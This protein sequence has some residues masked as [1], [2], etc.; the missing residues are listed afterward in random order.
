M[1]Y[2]PNVRGALDLHQKIYLPL[3]AEIP[4]LQLL[5]IGRSPSPEVQAIA[6]ASVEVTGT[7]ESIWPHLSKVD[8]F[9]FPMTTGAGLQNK[10]LEAMHAG[11]P[12]VTTEICL[13]SV[14]AREGDEILVGR[15]DD[16]L[17]AHVRAL[18]INP[19][20]ARELGMRGKQYVDHTFEMSRVIDRFENFLFPDEC[21]PSC[22]DSRQ[23]NTHP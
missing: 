19:K 7:V 13:K 6:E 21:A 14:G 20:F 2:A 15:N 18:L 16:E 5:V 22:R 9:V 23:L 17:R 1:G 11:K 12:V 10:I 8:V 3:K 4:E